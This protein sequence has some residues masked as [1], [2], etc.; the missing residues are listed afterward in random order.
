[1]RLLA[2]SGFFQSNAVEA[3]A[4]VS[5]AAVRVQK[6]IASVEASNIIRPSVANNQ[7]DSFVRQPLQSST[8]AGKFGPA[9]AGFAWLF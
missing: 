2:S 4:W 3:A 9:G 7:F 5:G 8:D 1:M 6:Q